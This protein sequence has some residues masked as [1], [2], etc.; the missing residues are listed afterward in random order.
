MSLGTLV[1]GLIAY[2]RTMRDLKTPAQLHREILYF[3]AVLHRTP[4]RD[5]RQRAHRALA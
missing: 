2:T 5:R 1:R 4:S 3:T